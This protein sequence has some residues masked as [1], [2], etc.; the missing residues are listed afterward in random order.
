MVLCDA[1]Y[2]DGATGKFTILGTFTR[3][4][5]RTLPIRSQFSVYFCVTD[6]LGEVPIGLRIVDSQSLLADD[7]GE[8]GVLAEM[9]GT[10]QATSPL[11]VVEGVLNIGLEFPREGVYHC[12]LFSGAEIL[13]S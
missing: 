2:R 1:I 9:D 7:N 6:A 5:A 11:M 13:M 8:E 10:L 3:I 12:E 4:V